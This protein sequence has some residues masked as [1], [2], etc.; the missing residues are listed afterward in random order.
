MGKRLHRTSIDLAVRNTIASSALLLLLL[1]LVFIGCERDNKLK[2]QHFLKKGMEEHLKGN[3][4]QAV[5][6]FSK[7]IELNPQD[8]RGYRSRGVAWHHKRDLDK[9]I[10]DLS[11]AILMDPGDALTYY[12]RGVVWHDKGRFGEA[13]ED[14]TQY[15]KLDPDSAGA[16]FNRG[17]AWEKKGDLDRAIADYTQ[18]VKLKSNDG[19]FYY[20]R[21]IAFYKRHE[22]DPAFADFT[23]TV[24]IRPED[25]DALSYFALFLAASPRDHHR[26]GTKAVQLAL[27]AVKRDPNYFSLSALAAAYAEIG[28]FEDATTTQEQAIGLLLK[29]GKTEELVGYKD[30]LSFYKARKPWRE[31]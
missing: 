17:C 16:Y 9:A 29:E 3:I 28:K 31:K 25:A 4:E 12:N 10:A 30:R 14:Y 15:I 18:A 11:K 1:C 13:I 21:G 27:S 8:A 6:D 23:K 20:N 7:A 5:A 24:E 22:F 2:S 26:D 19:A